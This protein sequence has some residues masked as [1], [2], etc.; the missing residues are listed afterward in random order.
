[1]RGCREDPRVVTLERRRT[2]TLSPLAPL[3]CDCL[4]CSRTAMISYV[5]VEWIADFLESLG[6]A[7]LDNHVSYTSRLFGVASNRGWGATPPSPIASST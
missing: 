5:A 4:C 1:L 2:L 6:R 3:V 7:E